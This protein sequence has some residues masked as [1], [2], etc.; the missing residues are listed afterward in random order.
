MHHITIIVIMIIFFILWSFIV[1]VCRLLRVTYIITY[2]SLLLGRAGR[3]GLLLLRCVVPSV[4]STGLSMG[5]T[6]V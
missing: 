2:R 3:E 6:N 5:C 1:A 4:F